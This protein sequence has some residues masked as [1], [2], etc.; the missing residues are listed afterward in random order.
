MKEKINE[1]ISIKL[2]FF[3]TIGILAIN[4]L[5]KGG[6]DIWAQTLTH[7]LSL[8]LFMLTIQYCLY[9]PILPVFLPLTILIA[10]I[11][12][13]L[14]NTV[15]PVTSIMEFYN[16]INY[17]LIFSISAVFFSTE[18]HI[19]LLT[20]LLIFAGISIAILD[21]L[22]P[23][24]IGTTLFPNPNIKTG[25]FI[26]II[27]FF[28]NEIIT[29]FQK[30][31]KLQG[32]ILSVLFIPIITS[33]YN[34][35]SNWG[36]FISFLSIALYLK[37]TKKTLKPIVQIFF[38]L[39]IT[40]ALTYLILKPS[41]DIYNRIQWILS[42]ISMIAAK[43]LTGFGPG[44][45]PHLIP[46]FSHTGYFTLY[47]HSFFI[48]FT[49]ENGILAFFG[50]AWISIILLRNIALQK[51]ND[52]KA[53]FTA[54]ISLIAYN[55]F[56]YNLF[57]PL[58]AFLFWTIA[59][60]FSSNS[61]HIF[62]LKKKIYRETI[63][64]LSFFIL[65]I[66]AGTHILKPFISTRYFSKGIYSLRI[67]NFSKSKKLF[68]KSLEFFPNYHLSQLGLGL[69]CIIENDLSSAKKHI[70]LSFPL[71]DNNPVYTIF[72]EGEL[73]LTNAKYDEAKIKFWKVIEL[74]FI[75]YGLNPKEH[76]TPLRNPI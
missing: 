30:N 73:L 37:I 27:P 76:M 4:I 49:A 29:T 18:K 44:S 66:F 6:W 67:G 25:F 69:L 58:I 52:S 64:I 54:L 43:P 21:M 45:T 34:A 22:Y 75:Q 50:L 15:T 8:I 40:V 63:I 72:K 16:W 51:S 14:I 56:E 57:I 7:A 24:I 74:R 11:L 59:G 5:F 62:T 60:S 26:I 1:P 68:H 65:L 42:G 39:V 70:S 23:P 38:F 3:L 53:A 55:L 19:Q 9:F 35:H 31:M 33:F 17:F 10:G 28:I 12:I 61:F 41:G 47:I 13:S 20:K 32:F 71:K 2:A 48:Q 46:I 36:N